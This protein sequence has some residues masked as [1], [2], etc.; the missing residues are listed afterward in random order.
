MTLLQTYISY[1][2]GNDIKQATMKDILLMNT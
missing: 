1:G 2:S